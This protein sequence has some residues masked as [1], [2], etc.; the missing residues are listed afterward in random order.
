MKAL[1]NLRWEELRRGLRHA[2]FLPHLPLIFVNPYYSIRA[3]LYRSVKKLAPKC[4]GRILD[5][6]CGS[7]PYRHLFKNR[8]YLG[9]DVDV[10]GHDHESSSIDLYFDGSH[11]PFDDSSFD[12]LLC[13]EVLEHVSDLE[14]L[15]QEMSRIIKPG[16]RLLVS[17]PF[18]WNEHEMPYDFRRF[19]GIGLE[20]KLISFGFSQ[21]ETLQTTHTL[22][23]L[24]QLLAVYITETYLKRPWFLKYALAPFLTAPLLILGKCLSIFPDKSALYHNTVSLFQRD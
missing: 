4:E 6:G 9:I 10:S 24:C 5:V 12:S 23:T 7:Q 21:I 19:T 3:S 1:L 11:I 16:G 22:E 20:K 13:F 15:L 2:S 17:V 14:T 8:E 18:V